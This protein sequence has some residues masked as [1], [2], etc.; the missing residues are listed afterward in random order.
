[1]RDEGVVFIA[2]AAAGG[3]WKIRTRGK[4]C[5]FFFFFN[6][7]MVTGLWTGIGAWLELKWDL[8]LFPHLS[9]VAEKGKERNI[10]GDMI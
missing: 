10:W 5:F 9:R 4:N 7:K 6:F 8:F 3:V 1:M 2:A